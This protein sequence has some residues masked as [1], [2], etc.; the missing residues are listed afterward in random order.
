MFNE[1]RKQ[2]NGLL[3]VHLPDGPTAQ[4][5][6][7]N[8][9]LS[10]DIKVSAAQHERVQR[11]AAQHDGAQCSMCSVQCAEHA[12]H[13]AVQQEA[14]GQRGRPACAHASPPNVPAALVCGTH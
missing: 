2:I 12:Q 10:T 3:L 1:D 11:S 13:G 4:F 9:V 8:L 6:L 7:S 14:A 5:R